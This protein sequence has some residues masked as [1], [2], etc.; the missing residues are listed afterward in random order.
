MVSYQDTLFRNRNGLVEYRYTLD[1]DEQFFSARGISP[2]VISATAS[3][4]H[5]SDVSLFEVDEFGSMSSMSVKLSFLTGV[6]LRESFNVFERILFRITRGHGY[7]R[8]CPVSEMIVDPTSGKLVEKNVF[9]VFFQGEKLAHK[10]R[11]ICESFGCNL[12]NISEHAS[13]RE[14]FAQQLETKLVEHNLILEKSWNERTQQL[15]TIAQVLNT[16]FVKVRRE[17]SIYHIMNLFNY[18]TGRKAL[19]AEGWVPSNSIHLVRSAL[20]LAHERSGSQTEPI[21]YEIPTKQT[22]PTY[23]PTNKFTAGFQAIVDAY[24]VPRYKEINPAVFSIVTFPFMFG[25]MF[26]DV[27]HGIGLL[28]FALFMIWKEK[29][30]ATRKLH[31]LIELPFLGR[32][33]ILCMALFSIYCGL[34]YNE[35]LSI[36]VK[37]APSMWDCSQAEHP[38][39]DKPHTPVP[40][41]LIIHPLDHEYAGHAKNI[42][43]FGIDYMWKGAVNELGY[44]NSIKMKL[45]IIIGVTQ[46]SLGIFLKMLNSIYFRQPVEL[47]FEA[48][49]QLV[50]LLSL[51]GYLSAL[52]FIKWCYPFYAYD[53]IH[54]PDIRPH[55]SDAPFLLTTMIY[56]FL[57]IGSPPPAQIQPPGSDIAYFELFKGQAITQ[58]ILVITAVTC[59]PVM[60]LVKPLWLKYQHNQTSIKKGYSILHTDEE[61]ALLINGHESDLHSNLYDEDDDNDQGEVFNFGEVFIHQIIET[62]E[63]VL[64]TIS[65]TASYLRLW[66]LSL[67]HSELATVFWGQGLVS[68]LGLPAFLGAGAFGTVI[69]WAAFACSS[70]GILMMLETLSA[71]LHALRLHW[72]E[73]MNKFYKGDGVAFHPFDFR[74]VNVIEN[75]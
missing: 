12:Y 58:L 38:P 71:F 31:E 8:S 27:G 61:S 53:R 43:P 32:Y 36:P 41:T 70:V 23:F 64:G 21:L 35:V 52:I 68:A 29:E 63:F 48:V 45:S 20:A 15:N 66:A 25:M 67:A 5:P 40:C 24:G 54:G 69:A 18:H 39:P 57:W 51:F 1:S 33:V 6:I 11:K 4:G 72:V 30:W 19:I 22:P 37:L 74:T 73:F 59:V 56:M 34:L 2:G 62:I 16:W 55:V 50:M 28:A 9:I 65:N 49:P 17:K 47:M 10:I 13:D 42:Y 3:L 44:Y 14:K 7:L 60:L 75:E 26:G 46:M